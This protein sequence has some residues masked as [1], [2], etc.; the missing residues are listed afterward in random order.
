MLHAASMSSE[1]SPREPRLGI[2]IGRVIIDGPAHPGGGDTAFF[3]GDEVAL[4]TTPE[5]AGA[6]ESIARLVR[7]L[8]GRVWL[9]QDAAGRGNTFALT[10]PLDPDSLR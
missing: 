7:L 3:R 6:V 2:D 9:V 4:L 5:M 8:G 10:L 1:R